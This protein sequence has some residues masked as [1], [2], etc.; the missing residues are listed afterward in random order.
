MAGYISNFSGLHTWQKRLVAQGLSHRSDLVAVAASLPPY[1][2]MTDEHKSSLQEVVDEALAV[3]RAYEKANLGTAVHAFT[4]DTHVS[5]PVPEALMEDVSSHE[6]MVMQTGLVTLASEVFVVN[7]RL[8]VAGTLDRILG[9]PA[10]GHA[11]VAD[12]KTGKQDLRKTMIQ[13]A[14]YADSVVYDW[15]EHRRIGFDQYLEERLGY[16]PPKMHPRVGLYVHVPR[17]QGQTTVHPLSLDEGRRMAK[18]CAE[19]REWQR[20]KEFIKPD[21]VEWLTQHRN[22][23]ALTAITNASTVEE[24]REVYAAWRWCWN[25]RL[26]KAGAARFAEIRSTA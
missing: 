15:R 7:D 4:D 23:P 2:Q 18:I 5:G 10:L 14:I 24:L 26:D 20:N 8:K 9:V 12:T 11:S 21:T 25:D 6:R 17:G 3:A 13:V 16:A 22:M 19:V 1:D